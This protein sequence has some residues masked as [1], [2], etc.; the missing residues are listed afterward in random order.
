ML[1]GRLVGYMVSLATIFAL[2][3]TG[4]RSLGL[5]PSPLPSNLRSEVSCLLRWT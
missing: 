4:I 5:P 1:L 3:L 2:F